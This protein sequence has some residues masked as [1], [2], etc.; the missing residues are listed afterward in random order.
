MTEPAGDAFPRSPDE[1]NPVDAYRMPLMEHLR[2]LRRRMVISLAAIILGVILAGAYVDPIWA[3]LVAPMVDAIHANGRGTMAITDPTEGVMTWFRVAAIAGIGASS[4]V[5]FFQFWQFVAPGL[6]PKE[7]RL[8]LP[9][10]FAST[11]LFLM[12]GAFCYFVVF[13]YAFPFLL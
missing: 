7:K 4:P 3:F 6:Y 5:V 13:K 2:E 12:G 10:V 1:F 11:S 8:V 9:L